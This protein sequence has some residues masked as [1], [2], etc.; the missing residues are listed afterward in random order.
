MINPVQ[1][2]NKFVFQGVDTFEA[3]DSL[4]YHI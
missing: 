2:I 1:P 3:R 4:K